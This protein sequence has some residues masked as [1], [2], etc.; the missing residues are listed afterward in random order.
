M[1]ETAAKYDLYSH[2]E[3]NTQVKALTWLEDESKWSV[4]IL[5]K[6]TKEEDVKL[7]DIV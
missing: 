5:N 4:S 3:F 1:M 6:D 2:I 7:F